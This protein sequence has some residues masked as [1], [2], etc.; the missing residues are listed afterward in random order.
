MSKFIPVTGKLPDNVNVFEKFQDGLYLGTVRM[1]IEG[2]EERGW[3]WPDQEDIIRA[4]NEQGLDNF[5]SPDVLVDKIMAEMDPEGG[6]EPLLAGNL[7]SVSPGGNLEYFT[8]TPEIAK[9]II[10]INGEGAF[11][12]DGNIDYMAAYNLVSFDKECAEFYQ[13]LKPLVF[14]VPEPKGGDRGDYKKLTKGDTR[15]A[16]GDFYYEIPTGEE[17]FIV[18]AYVGDMPKPEVS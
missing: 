4:I 12:P 10:A 1:K 3:W 18:S 13:S 7:R 11:Q 2:L 5:V 16:E 9:K 8:L 15:E 14:E 6:S 17:V